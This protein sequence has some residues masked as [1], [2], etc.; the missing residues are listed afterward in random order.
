[1]FINKLFISF[2][3]SRC[4]NQVMVCMGD[5]GREGGRG[6]VEKLVSIE[7]CVCLEVR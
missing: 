2:V 3:I 5:E 1:M 6:V 4:S 7:E